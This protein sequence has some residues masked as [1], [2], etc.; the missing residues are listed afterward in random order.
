MLHRDVRDQ[1][2]TNETLPRNVSGKT[3]TIASQKDDSDYMT[4]PVRDCSSEAP[5]VPPRHYH[6]PTASRLENILLWMLIPVFLQ[7][8]FRLF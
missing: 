2:L 5:P 8:E 3:S 6:E 1:P 4:I 7:T